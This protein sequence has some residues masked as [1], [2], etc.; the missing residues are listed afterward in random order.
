VM[1]CNFD[2]VIKVKDRNFLISFA[3]GERHCIQLSWESEDG[4][5]YQNGRINIGFPLKSIQ[6]IWHAALKEGLGL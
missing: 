3:L 5:M 2:H 6:E 4:D 1:V